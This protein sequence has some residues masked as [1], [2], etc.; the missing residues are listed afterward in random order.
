LVDQFISVETSDYS[1]HLSKLFYQLVFK[2]RHGGE[3]DLK[4]INEA[5]E[6]LGKTLDVYE[7]LSK[8]LTGEFNF[9]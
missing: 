5:R 2:K 4:I 6:E 9:L 1:P 7:K 3:P 8:D